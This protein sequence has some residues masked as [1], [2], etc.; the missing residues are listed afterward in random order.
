MQWQ[1][2]LS[3]TREAPLMESPQDNL[4]QPLIAIGPPCQ[5]YGRLA[6][7]AS[8]ALSR[9]GTNRPICHELN[10]FPPIFHD[11][12]WVCN[13][14]GGGGVGSGWLSLYPV[15]GRDQPIGNA[16]FH[17]ATSRLPGLYPGGKILARFSAFTFVGEKRSR[18]NLDRVSQISDD[19]S[20][21]FLPS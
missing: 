9:G 13:L 5:R 1:H 15:W 17:E 3:T 4:L 10:S 6:E 18:M 20:L 16:L 7:L 19:N 14:S 11:A 8:S 21:P 12:S 2:D